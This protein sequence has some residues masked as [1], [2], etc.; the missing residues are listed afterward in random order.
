M[1]TAAAHDFD[2]VT[3]AQPGDVPASAPAGLRTLAGLPAVLRALERAAARRV[4][5][6][7][8]EVASGPGWTLT[9]GEAIAWLE[10]QPDESADAI[11]TDPPYSSGGAFRGDRMSRP[12]VKY[13]NNETRTR[14]PEFSGDSRDGRS[15]ALWSERW[16][17]EALRVAREGAPICVFT[18]WRQLA[19]T[20]DAL[21]VAGW[22]YRGVIPWDKTEGVRPQPGRFRQ[23][24]EYVVWGSRGPM[25]FERSILAPST[26]LAGALP[27]DS[28]TSL[29]RDLVAFAREALG[30]SEDDAHAA[31]AH[32]LDAR[33]L[34]GYVREVVK[35]REKRHVTA[36]P[37]RVL[38][39]LVRICEPGGLILDPFAGSCT[40]G[41]AALRLGYRFAGCELTREIF[42]I[43]AAA[44]SEVA[45]G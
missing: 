2:D 31:A 1:D 10:A 35:S 34:P 3:D 33:G 30:L 43:G 26:A 29:Q 25:S 17:R 45:G 40:T 14:Y 18:D 42:E 15:F 22:V 16:M 44:L 11:V 20:I 38:E 41:V 5:R 32:W 9:R 36:K 24:A 7:T 13:Q 23:Q 8:P 12:S 4:A 37:V 21:G 28:T 27:T 39:H 19:T 6:R